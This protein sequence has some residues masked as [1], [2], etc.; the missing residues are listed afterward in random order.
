MVFEARLYSESGNGTYFRGQGRSDAEALGTLICHC[1]EKFN[2]EVEIVVNPDEI[3][4]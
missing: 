1:P 2:C 4:S 3:Q